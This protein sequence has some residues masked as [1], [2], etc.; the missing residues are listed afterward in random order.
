MHPPPEPER[1]PSSEQP[2]SDEAST[3]EKSSSAPQADTARPP[4]PHGERQKQK[5][6][7]AQSDGS[8]ASTVARGEKQRKATFMAKMRGE[9][10]V[11][12]GKLERKPEKVE[13]GKMLKRGGSPPQST[14]AQV[15]TAQT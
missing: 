5:S 15:E 11:L 4:Q 8:G 3:D 13:A 14:Q 2:V 6:D 1:A 12:L 9:A 10:Q 7:D